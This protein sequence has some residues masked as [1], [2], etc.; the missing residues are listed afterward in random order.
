MHKALRNSVSAWSPMFIAKL[1][2]VART[3]KQP[4]CPSADEQI[5]KIRWIYTGEYYSA[6]KNECESVVVR[7][8]NLEPDI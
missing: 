2:T 1:F 3:C 4:R 5:K 6:I 8:V 7:W